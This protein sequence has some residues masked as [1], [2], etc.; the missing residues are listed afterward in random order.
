MVDSLV[1]L[2]LLA[3]T[4]ILSLATAHQA[5]RMAQAA[6]E[7][8]QATGVLRYLVEQS[9]VPV[10]ASSGQAGHVAWKVAISPPEAT[11]NAASMCVHAITLRDDRSRRAYSASTARICQ[12]SIRP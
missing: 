1:A 11:A 2:T 5:Q 10:A 12:A 6:L 7:V 3:T 9:G 8:R 4:I